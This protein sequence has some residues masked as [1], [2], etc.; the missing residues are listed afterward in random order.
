MGGKSL[1]QFKLNA[2]GYG[3]FD[4][5]ISLEN[6]GGF[7]SIRYRFPRVK[8]TSSSKLR[9]RI[10]GDGKDYQIRVK[11]KSST[12]YSYITRIPTTSLWEDIEINLKDMYPAFRG[13]Q[14][15]IPNFSHAFVEQIAFLIGNKK[16]ENFKLIIDSIKLI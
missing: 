15:D 10:K 7:S 11:D 13:R 9:I 3:V 8:T 12:Y 1:S 2:D 16:N 5:E 6:N 14:L 4:G